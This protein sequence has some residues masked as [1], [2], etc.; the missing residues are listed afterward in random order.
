[1]QKE[2]QQMVAWSGL[3]GKTI[4]EEE[5]REIV[6]NVSSFFS[7]LKAWNDKVNPRDTRVRELRGN[8]NEEHLPDKRPV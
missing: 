8:A 5:T 6:A 7:L 1:M 2:W 3:Y 4:G